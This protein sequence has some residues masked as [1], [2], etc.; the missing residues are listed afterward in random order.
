MERDFSR[1][2][3]IEHGKL[4]Q[5]IYRANTPK[6]LI[7][8]KCAP[9][10]LHKVPVCQKHRGRYTQWS[11]TIHA[12]SV[13]CTAQA[14]LELSDLI[15]DIPWLSALSTNRHGLADEASRRVKARAG[16]GQNLMIKYLPETGMR[17][18]LQLYRE[19]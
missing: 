7:F 18:Q 13:E 16:T 12:F 8:V 2:V 4:F 14:A 15:V 17:I 1:L 10:S 5:L 3:Y 19:I 11:L 6:I 9:L